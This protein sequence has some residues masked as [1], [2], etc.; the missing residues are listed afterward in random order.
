LENKENG[1]CGLAAT[2]GAGFPENQQHEAGSIGDDPITI[3]GQIGVRQGPPDAGGITAKRED[4]SHCTMVVLTERLPA[5]AM[6][7]ILFPMG[8]VPARW[9]QGPIHSP[10]NGVQFGVEITA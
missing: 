2:V 7:T 4:T 9:D 3:D 1:L 10:S 6:R 5:V 8:T